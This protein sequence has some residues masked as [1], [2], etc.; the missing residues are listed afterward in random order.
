MKPFA[1][2]NSKKSYEEF[3]QKL[4]Q[5]KNKERLE[6][7]VIGFESTGPYAEPLFHFLRKKPVR[8]VQVN[9]GNNEC[10]DTHQAAF[11]NLKNYL[12]PPMD[13]AVSSL[14]DDL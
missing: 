8:L 3:W 1:F 11:P 10:W 4:C 14:L 9:L 12:L 13:R 2:Y 5:F 6:Q 7:I